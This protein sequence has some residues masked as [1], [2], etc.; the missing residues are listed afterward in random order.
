ME[1]RSRATRIID[2]RFHIYASRSAAKHPL[3]WSRDLAMPAP[4]HTLPDWMI[5]LAKQVGM[6]E[7][8]RS[9]TGALLPTGVIV[10][11]AAKQLK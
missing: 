11:S 7:D 9:A 6:I 1:Y 10:G 2:E 8:L 4:P 3:V 5:E